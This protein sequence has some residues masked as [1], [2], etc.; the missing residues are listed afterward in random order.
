VRPGPRLDGEL[1]QV[2]QVVRCGAAKRQADQAPDVVQDWIYM[3]LAFIQ[4]IWFL[5][6]RKKKLTC[7]GAL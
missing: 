6:V 7:V 5:M 2:H 1:G 4:V 3:S